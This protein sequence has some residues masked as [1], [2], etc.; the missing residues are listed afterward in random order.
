MRLAHTP[1]TR[2]IKVKAAANPYD[3]IWERD[4]EAR[5]GVKVAATLQGRRSLLS[6]W[7]EQD[8]IC[9]VC[10][11]SITQ[12]TGWHHHHIVWRSKGGSDGAAHRVLQHP[13]CH[14]QV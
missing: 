10:K 8:G 3:S 9:P 1:S 4:L 6:L 13:S 14:Q 5:L 12:L 2:H 7:R 11:P